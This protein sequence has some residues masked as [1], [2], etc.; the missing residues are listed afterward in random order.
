MKALWTTLI[1]LYLISDCA[2]T[3]SQTSDTLGFKRFIFTTSIFEYIPSQL[4][5]GNF[6]IGSE[7]YLKKRKSLYINL[8]FVKS[9]GPE[10]PSGGGISSASS[11]LS[12]PS[13]STIGFRI[14]AE[15]KYFL[16]RHK[17]FQPAILLFWPH[18][19]Q[20]KSQELQ[21]TGYYVAVHSSYQFTKTIRDE[22]VVD[23]RDDNSPFR[24]HYKVNNYSVNRNSLQL[25]LKFGYQSIKKYG[26]V[27]DYAV[28]FGFEYL[29]SSAFNKLGD[30]TKHEV[31]RNKLFDTGDGLFPS[32]VY[33]VRIGWAH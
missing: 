20:F 29:S 18:I 23:F 31:L 17:I 25:H 9:Y 15:G 12:V 3:Q 7:I 19:L 14:Q 1:I 10:R 24:L 32:F 33:Q 21:N 30:S 16:N 6:N 4:N 13:I 5:T 8:G 26:L 27:V 28:G 2:F 22:T 11:F